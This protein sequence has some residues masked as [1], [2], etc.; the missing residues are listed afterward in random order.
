MERNVTELWDYFQSFCLIKL[1]KLNEVKYLI[2][3]S[4]IKAK[5]KTEIGVENCNAAYGAK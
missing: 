5:F 2:N 4:L 1:I 3:N